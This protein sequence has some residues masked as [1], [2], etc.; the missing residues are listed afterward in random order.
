LP[1]ANVTGRN[2]CIPGTPSSY[3]NMCLDLSLDQDVDLVFVEYA[4]ND[5]ATNSVAANNNALVYE[6]LL[7]KILSR[8]NKPAV[9]LM[10]VRRPPD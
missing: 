6:R 10:Q 7:R 5:G 2:G 1:H 8:P 4:L 9:V 3:M